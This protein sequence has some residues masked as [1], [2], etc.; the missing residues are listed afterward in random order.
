VTVSFDRCYDNG[1]AVGLIEG[2]REQRDHRLQCG[3]RSVLLGY[4]IVTGLPA[5]SDT[6][7]GSEQNVEQHDIE[8]GPVIQ[9][10]R[11][12]SI[13]QTGIAAERCG[14]D[15]QLRFGKP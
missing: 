6:H 12:E 3:R 5:R 7:L 9:Q 11:C 2:A 1:R 15:P 4:E 14:S 8:R 13:E 10:I